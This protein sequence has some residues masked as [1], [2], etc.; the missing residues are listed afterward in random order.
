MTVAPCRQ[1]PV[2]LL[3]F[4]RDSPGELALAYRNQLA[5]ARPGACLQESAMVCSALK[6]SRMPQIL[7]IEN[8]MCRWVE[9]KRE[10]EGGEVQGHFD[11]MQDI[12]Q[13]AQVGPSGSQ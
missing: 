2:S 10:R 1:G 6:P 12:R 8:T 5:P 13:A 9:A 4:Y 7:S 3:L 11:L